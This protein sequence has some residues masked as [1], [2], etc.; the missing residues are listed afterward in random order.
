MPISNN[1]EEFPFDWN[2]APEWATHAVRDYDGDWYWVQAYGGEPGIIYK[3]G[4]SRLR[5]AYIKWELIEAGK[6]K[7]LVFK[8][9]IK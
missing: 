4:R 1:K 6:D 7:V 8:K 2:E 5:F 9:P 3:E